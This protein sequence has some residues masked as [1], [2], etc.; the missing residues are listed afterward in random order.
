MEL[1][2]LLAEDGT[3]IGTAPK[4]TVHTEATPLHLA[5]SC[6]VFDREGRL[7]VTR[8]ALSKRTW[9]GVW[10]NSFCGHPRPDED[11]IEAVIRRGTEEIGARPL[12]VT[13]VLPSFRY[14][15]IDASGTVERELCPV[16]VAV[17][18]DPIEPD[19]AEVMEWAWARPADLLLAVSSAP[20]A[21]SPW[22]QEQLP[23]LHE[24]GRI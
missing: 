13:S 15:A 4:D 7:L 9:P 10:T 24:A 21:F 22:L 20:F 16:H 11:M 23:L 3:A 19:P 1:V 18:D 17:V 5:F 12:E 6:Y 14:H 8:R 2:T